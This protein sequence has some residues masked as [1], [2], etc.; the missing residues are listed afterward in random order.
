[1]ILFDEDKSF[2]VKE[3]RSGEFINDGIVG[4]YKLPVKYL[5][6][7]RVSVREILALT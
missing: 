4:G 5:F 3:L 7:D 1:L 2:K 6:E